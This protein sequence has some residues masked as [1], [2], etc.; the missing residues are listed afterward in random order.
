MSEVKS[1][2]SNQ[3]TFLNLTTIVEN[4]FCDAIDEEDFFGLFNACKINVNL[5]DKKRQPKTIEN[6]KR[7]NKFLLKCKNK[8][9]IPISDSLI[10]LERKY[11]P[12]S[13]LILALDETNKEIL[14][15]EMSEKYFIKIQRNNLDDFFED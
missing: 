12:F 3:Q 2:F 4:E 9:N 5:L 6:F 14:K 10:H 15:K 8:M 11:I 13:K 7:F 1:E